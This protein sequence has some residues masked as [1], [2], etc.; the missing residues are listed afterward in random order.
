[1]KTL[2]LRAFHHLAEAEGRIHGIPAEDVHFHEVGSV[3]AIGDI[4]CAAA[5]LCW[6]GVDAWAASSINV[7]SGMVECA[8]GLY[9]VPAP[10]TAELLR[11]MPTYSAGPAV[12]MVTPTGAAL[13]KALAPNF[14]PRSLTA[15][16]IG[17]GAGGRNP[18]RFPN[19]LRLSIGTPISSAEPAPSGD[20]GETVTVMECALDDATPQ[21]I[22]HVMEQAMAAGALDV[23]AGAVIMKKGR[24]GTLLTVLATAETAKALESL[25]L[26]DTTTLGL[27]IREERRVV[28]PRRFVN[29]STEFGLIAVKVGGSDDENVMPEYED[30]RRAALAHGAS[31]EAG[32]AGGAG[33]VL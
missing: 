29:V 2:A 26:R 18:A 22:A 3:D 4:T 1:M 25:L 13:L 8:H 5:G 9:P 15:G 21:L 12:E 32:A 30:C 10:A 27:R 14:A 6:L 11:G 20:E 7:G 16:T 33:G 19:V 23:M 24:L 31:A 17:Y 28:L